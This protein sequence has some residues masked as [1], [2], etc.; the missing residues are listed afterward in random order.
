MTPLNEDNEANSD[1][2]KRCT[3]GWSNL[4]IKCYVNV[5]VDAQIVEEC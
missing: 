2:T 5:K 3:K 4:T 1:H